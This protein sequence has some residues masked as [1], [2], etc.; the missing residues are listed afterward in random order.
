MFCL[1]QILKGLNTFIFSMFLLKRTKKGPR[2]QSSVN[3]LWRCFLYF[4]ETPSRCT[5]HF[6]GHKV[7]QLVLNSFNGP[8]KVT[9]LAREGALYLTPPGDHPIPFT[10][11]TKV[12][13]PSKKAFFYHF[14]PTLE[15]V[16]RCYSQPC[17]S[18]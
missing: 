7:H 3:S 11:S 18:L 10:Y 12:L 8:F 2:W 4:P 13:N 15:K 14:L 1:F 5:L 16:Q 9:F 17:T 6:R